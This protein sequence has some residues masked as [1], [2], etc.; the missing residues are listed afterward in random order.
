M[1]GVMRKWR[2][3]SFR[4]RHGKAIEGGDGEEPEMANP[5]SQLVTQKQIESEA[6]K[7]W[8]SEGKVKPLYNRKLWEYAYILEAIYGNGLMDEGASGLGFGVGIEPIPAVAAKYGCR[9][10]ATDLDVEEAESKRWMNSKQH[11]VSVNALN[12]QGI[13]DPERFKELASYRYADMNNIDP[14]LQKAG[15]DFVWSCSALEHLG[16]LETGARF[17]KE[18]MK[19][20]KP[21]GIAVHTTE[22]NVSSSEDTV[23]EGGTVYFRRK[24]LEALADDLRKGGSLIELNLHP[25]N[26]NYDKDFDVRPWRTEPHLK[27]LHKRRYIVTS[28]GLIVK[29]G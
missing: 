11:A 1:K 24:D 18:S 21:G 7:R 17:I 5:V 14:S 26:G 6:F 3:L 2:Y 13:C 22:F 12:A 23:S 28:I 20:L 27:L 29:N 9:I 19:C 15:F 25:G 10:V 8:C 4:I 16:S